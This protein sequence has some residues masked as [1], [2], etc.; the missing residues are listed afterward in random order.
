MF[1]CDEELM[2]LSFLKTSPETFFSAGEVCRKAGNKK[3]VVK[4]P[5]WALPYLVSLKDK[6]LVEG[7]AQG[8]YRVKIDRRENQD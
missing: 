5:R 3:L 4:N 6:D 7:D 1:I 8:H 2:I